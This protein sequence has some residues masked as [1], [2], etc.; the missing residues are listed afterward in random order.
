MPRAAR[1][2]LPAWRAERGTVAKNA[3]PRV[4]AGNAAR[5]ARLPRKAVD[6]SLTEEDGQQRRA[7]ALASDAEIRRILKGWK[8]TTS[9]KALKAL[10]ESLPEIVAA[11]S[12]VDA[13][14]PTI[15]PGAEKWR[16]SEGNQ[17]FLALGRKY[18][19]EVLSLLRRAGQS[20]AA[21]VDPE[22]ARILNLSRLPS[23]LLYSIGPDVLLIPAVGWA[24][25]L[26]IR[27]SCALTIPDSRPQLSD[28]EEWNRACAERSGARLRGPKDVLK[29]SRF[30]RAELR[31]IADYFGKAAD[32]AE[33]RDAEFGKPLR[34]LRVLF[35]YRGLRSTGYSSADAFSK[36]ARQDGRSIS[37]IKSDVR[38]AR[39][40]IGLPRR[41][42]DRLNPLRQRTTRFFRVGATS[43]DRRMIL[44]P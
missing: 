35:E 32:F 44:V 5:G 30:F 43:S 41:T 42:F 1:S 14:F 9:R 37:A 10:P 36:I 27:E 25:W 29:S 3:S 26:V 18:G 17:G 4:R 12:R 6:E 33:R 38:E 24:I 16:A 11:L 34:P 40:R 39:K 19:F 20:N 8:R 28:R 2:S 15:V 31:R 22:R 7:F 13:G 21:S 23:E